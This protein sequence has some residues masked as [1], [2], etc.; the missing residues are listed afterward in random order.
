[1]NRRSTGVAAGI[2]VALL[3]TIG[4]GEDRTP[5]QDALRDAERHLDDVRSGNMD[6]RL[7][8]SSESANAGPVGFIV[9]G[10][11]AV[12]DDKGD[13]PVADLDYVRVTDGSRR[14]TQFISTG[15]AAFVR[16]D[17]RLVEL[18]D[19]Q[20]ER[21]RV[22]DG[23]GPQGLEGLSLTDWVE[24]PKVTTGPTLDGVRT[25]RITGA[26]DAVPAINDLVALA[27]GF[28]VDDEDAPRRLEGD[29]AERVR[30]AARTST[31]TL[32]VGREDKLLRRLDLTIEFSLQRIDDN[33]RKALRGLT[34]AELSLKIDLT[35]VNEPVRVTSP[36]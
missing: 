24:S 15:R 8:A 13:L 19:Q 12:G 27:T 26:V 36:E 25:Q 6:L 3:A 4:C 14:T 10:R 2:A 16:L 9:D 21:L 30:R 28:G 33:V 32:L 1:V 11:F 18:T 7:L 17:G 34:G 29:A 31:V 22:R 23:D 20:L 5:A 35:D